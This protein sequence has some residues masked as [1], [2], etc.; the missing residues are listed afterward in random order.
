[1]IVPLL[2]VGDPKN[3][4]QIVE[5]SDALRCCREKG[6]VEVCEGYCM[7]RV[8]S[9]RSGAVMGICGKWFEDISKCVA[10][11]FIHI[12]VCLIGG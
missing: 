1:M 6:V 7:K 3:S 5:D 8:A 10:G 12:V 11:K 2:L 4:T 9:S